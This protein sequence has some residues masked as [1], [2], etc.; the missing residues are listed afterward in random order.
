MLRLTTAY[1]LPEVFTSISIDMSRP[2]AGN[3]ALQQRKA[4]LISL[5]RDLLLS[6]SDFYMVRL[7]QALFL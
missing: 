6:M 5:V 7:K 1:P 2:A 3:V 4:F